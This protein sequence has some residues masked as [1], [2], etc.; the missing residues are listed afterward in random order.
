MENVS[1]RRLVSSLV[2]LAATLS[3]ASCS[4]S[5]APAGARVRCE[6]VR[7]HV[8]DLQLAQARAHGPDLDA[9]IVEAHRAAMLATLGEPYLDECEE[10]GPAWI[11]CAGGGQTPSAVAACG[12]VTP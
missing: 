8:I 2:G 7:D 10:R 1:V 5:D 6:A 12:G 4:S 3:L 11:E 9:P